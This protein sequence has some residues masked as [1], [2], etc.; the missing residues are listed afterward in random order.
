MRD[1][2]DSV[3]IKQLVNRLSK[4]RISVGYTEPTV[5]VSEQPTDAVPFVSILTGDTVAIATTALSTE[6][7]GAGLLLITDGSVAGSSATIASTASTGGVP[8][9]SDCVNVT[10][11]V[12]FWITVCEAAN[13]PPRSAKI[14]AKQDI[15][16]IFSKKIMQIDG[17]VSTPPSSL[18]TSTETSPTTE[19]QHLLPEP[20]KKK[21]QHQVQF[22]I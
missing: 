20:E 9:S 4:A 21:E 18:P 15:S 10:P 14:S 8:V 12:E 13:L 3:H 5:S 11:A 6:E 7:P 17:N 2:W 1:I 19:D 16:N 22:Q